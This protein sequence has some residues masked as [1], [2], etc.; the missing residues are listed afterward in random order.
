MVN[1][2]SLA[3]DGK[4]DRRM[5]IKYPMYLG[6]KRPFPKKLFLR[7]LQQILS[8]Q[9]RQPINHSNFWVKLSFK[10]KEISILNKYLWS[11]V[12]DKSTCSYGI[13]YYID[14]K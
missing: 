3:L 4:Y 1:E 2:F 6:L 8:W 12:N 11:E 10:T 5:T 14:T 7:E 13:K 9:F